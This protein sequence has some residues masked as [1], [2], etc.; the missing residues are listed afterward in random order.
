MSQDIDDVT[1]QPFSAYECNTFSYP[2]YK[3]WLHIKDIAE[4]K[5]AFAISSVVIDDRIAGLHLFRFQ[6]DAVLIR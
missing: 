6:R 2:S 3:A 1:S 5:G 4:R